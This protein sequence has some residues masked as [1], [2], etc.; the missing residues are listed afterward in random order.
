M[1][2][3]WRVPNHLLWRKLSSSPLK[4]IKEVASDINQ[5]NHMHSPFLPLSLSDA[6]KRSWAVVSLLPCVGVWSSLLPSLQ[7]SL[8]YTSAAYVIV[9]FDVTEWKTELLHPWK[10]FDV[11]SRPSR[12]FFKKKEHSEIL[13]QHP[14]CYSR[15]TNTC[16]R[17]K[18]K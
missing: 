1:N 12:K 16:G 5:A 6:E 7:G 9:V 8:R 3:G 17:C 15:C 18:E 14:F 4:S 11:H 10:I 2:S 13:T